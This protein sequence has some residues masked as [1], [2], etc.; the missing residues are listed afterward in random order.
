MILSGWLEFA[1]ETDPDAKRHRP[2]QGTYDLFAAPKADVD[3]AR[4]RGNAAMTN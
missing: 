3:T 2:H 4:F 1:R